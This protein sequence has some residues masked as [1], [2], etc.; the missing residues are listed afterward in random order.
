MKLALKILLG[1]VLAVAA[2]TGF[3]MLLD[4]VVGKFV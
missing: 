2:F 1:L 3:I 4:W